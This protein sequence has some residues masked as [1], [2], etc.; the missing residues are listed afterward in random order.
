LLDDVLLQG[1]L[2]GGLYGLIA[3]GF[4]I[5]FKSSQVLNLAYG[6]M[7]LVLAYLLYFLLDSI[8]LPLWLGVLLIFAAGAGM[9]LLMER[10][11]IRPLIGQPFFSILVL[12]LMLMFLFKGLVVLT[13]GGETF[14]YDFA[15]MHMIRFGGTQVLPAALW[16]FVVAIFIFLLLTFL[17]RYTKIG[18]AM[19]VVSTSQTIAQSL[20]ITVKRI[21]SLSWLVSG[22]FAAIC[23]ILLGS[24]YMVDTGMGDIGLGKG[25]VVVL[26][27]GLNSLP[28]AL[29][30]GL[31]LGLV[32]SLGGYYWAE[33]TQ[34]MP[35]LLMLFILLVRPWG[36]FGEMRRIERI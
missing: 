29:A 13:W 14:H 26:I 28:G 3:L 9:G 4:V 16:S 7:I 17:F 22:M 34:V 6:E 11:F 24:V 20:G 10:A 33:L 36:L 8:G 31:I 25:L 32:E 2:V 18:L 21:F 1:F 27:G 23:A 19:R 15:H 35:W 30:G 12:T 5:V